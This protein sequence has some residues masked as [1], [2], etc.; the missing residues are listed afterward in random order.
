MASRASLEISTRKSSVNS[1]HFSVNFICSFFLFPTLL[2]SLLFFPFL[3]SFL[4][5]SFLFLLLPLLPSFSPF[6]FPSLLKK[7]LSPT[8]LLFFFFSPHLSPFSLYLSLLCS[9]F[10]SFLSIIFHSTNAL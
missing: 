6:P 8:S 5:A 9:P 10:F 7:I 1:L 2:L 4:P 3:S